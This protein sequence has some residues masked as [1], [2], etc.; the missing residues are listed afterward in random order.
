MFMLPHQAGALVFW[1]ANICREFA[2]EFCRCAAM[3]GW[4]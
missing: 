1:F 3:E 4:P 2:Y